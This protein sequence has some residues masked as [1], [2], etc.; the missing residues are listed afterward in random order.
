MNLETLEKPTATVNR[1]VGVVVLA[2]CVFM[3]IELIAGLGMKNQAAVETLTAFMGSY[4]I[5]GVVFAVGI[6][7]MLVFT[8]KYVKYAKAFDRS[9]CNKPFFPKLVTKS[10]IMCL[11]SAM[12][13][14]L[15]GFVFNAIMGANNIQLN[16]EIPYLSV[17]LFV[18]FAFVVVYIICLIEIKDTHKGEKKKIDDIHEGDENAD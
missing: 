5:W 6:P 15:T 13:F 16:V 10:G 1:I 14:L 2:E 7:L 18:V 12:M 9:L 8:V 4:G 17:L 3:V 11:F